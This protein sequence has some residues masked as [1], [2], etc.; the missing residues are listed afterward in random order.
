MTN[1]LYRTSDRFRYLENVDF[2]AG[3][4]DVELGLFRLVCVDALAGQEV[5]D[6]VLAVAVT[7]GGSHLHICKRPFNLYSDSNVYI[8]RSDLILIWDQIF[9]L[10]FIEKYYHL[11]IESLKA[12]LLK[13]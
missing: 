11:A 5:D 1:F 6:V 8:V 4:V 9:S 2:S 3:S 7:I 12:I 13:Q 10:T